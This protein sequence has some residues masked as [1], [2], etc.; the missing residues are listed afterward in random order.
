MKRNVV[1]YRLIRGSKSYLKKGT[2][3]TPNIGEN[4]FFLL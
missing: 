3:L 1:T 4:S 2:F